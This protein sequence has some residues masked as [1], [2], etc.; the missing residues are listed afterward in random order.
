MDNNGPT[1]DQIKLYQ[2]VAKD[3]V[4]QHMRVELDDLE[5]AIQC[6]A[7]EWDI[8][9]QYIREALGARYGGYRIRGLDD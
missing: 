2:A 7:I 5:E 1:D 3:C 8:D 4:E 6:Q 9:P